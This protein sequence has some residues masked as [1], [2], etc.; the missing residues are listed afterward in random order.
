MDLDRRQQKDGS[1]DIV[2]GADFYVPHGIALYWMM[3][4]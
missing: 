4:H 1:E 3:R 2:G